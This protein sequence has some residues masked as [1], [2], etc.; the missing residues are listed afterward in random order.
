MDLQGIHS[1]AVCRTEFE[2]I[3]SNL[4]VKDEATD[5]SQIVTYDVEINVSGCAYEEILAE[6]TEDAYSVKKSVECTREARTIERFVSIEESGSIRETAEVGTCTGILWADITPELRGTYYRKDEDKLVCE[7]VW[8]CRFII[9]DADGTPCAAVREIPFSL[10]RPGN[11]NAQP[12]RN[13]TTL[14]L[15]DLSWSLTDAAHVEIRGTYRWSGVL[16]G[17]ET[18]DAVTCVT[19]KSDRPRST[20]AVILYYGEKGESAWNIAKEH[21][22][23]YGEFLRTNNLECDELDQDKMLMILCY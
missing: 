6:W 21:A 9:T 22:C 3:S 10:E 18:G 2:L 19:E 12:I 13:D 14:I 20:D 8:D 7:G 16:F 23:P 15:T 1:E 5:G 4:L 11:G 17:R